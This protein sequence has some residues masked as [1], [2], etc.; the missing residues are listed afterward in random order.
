MQSCQAV[1]VGVVYIHQKMH[2]EAREVLAQVLL[3]EGGSCSQLYQ[4]TFCTCLTPPCLGC[5]ACRTH[6]TCT[7]CT[8]CTTSLLPVLPV[9]LHP[10]CTTCM[11]SLPPVLFVLLHTSAC[12]GAVRRAGGVP[13]QKCRVC[14][15]VAARGVYAP[16]CLQSAACCPLYCLYGWSR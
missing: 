6:P 4:P 12:T 13:R 2:I 1:T 7:A 16:S 10:T 14:R 8:P 9:P 15:A 5:T 11:N 3:Q